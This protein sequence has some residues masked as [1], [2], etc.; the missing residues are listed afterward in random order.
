MQWIRLLRDD[1]ERSD[2]FSSLL[3]LALAI[4]RSHG[5][6]APYPVFKLAGPLWIIV[7][8]FVAGV[9]ALVGSRPQAGP[10]HV[11]SHPSGFPSLRSALSAIRSYAR[12]T[13]SIIRRASSLAKLEAR[14]RASSALMRQYLESRTGERII[15][16]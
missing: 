8:G 16:P 13:S 1:I 3:V 7:I 4:C 5:I 10:C 11:S 9:V 6:V 2:F 14:D 15:R 12:A